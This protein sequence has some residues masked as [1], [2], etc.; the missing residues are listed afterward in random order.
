MGSPWE[1][2]ETWA[3]NHTTIELLGMLRRD[4]EMLLSDE[5]VPDRHSVDA[6]ITVVDE[7]VSR[8]ELLAEGTGNKCTECGVVVPVDKM[9]VDDSVYCIPCWDKANNS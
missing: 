8:V 4:F 9:A 3:K 2:K 6:S 1:P 7:L 5:W